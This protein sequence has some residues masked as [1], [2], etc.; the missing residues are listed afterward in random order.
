MVEESGAEKCTEKSLSLAADDVFE[1]YWWYA[2]NTNVC[3]R[4]FVN[5]ATLTFVHKKEARQAANRLLGNGC[6]YVPKFGNSEAFIKMTDEMPLLLAPRDKIVTLNIFGRKFSVDFTTSEDWSTERV[7]L[8][9]PDG[10]VSFTDGSLCKGK[11]GASIFSDILNVRESYAL[12]S[13]ATVFQSEVYAILACSEYC[14]S[15]GIVNRVV[16]ICSD[17]RTALLA[18]KSCAVSSRVV[19]QC[20][21]SIQ[22]LALSNRVQLVWV[23]G[24]FG[25]H[26]NSETDALA[27]AGLSSD[28]VRRAL[29]SV[30]TF[31]CQAEG[32]KVVTYISLRLMKLG[33]CL[34]SVENVAEKAQ[35]RIDEILTEA[36]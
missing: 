6:S 31:E 17:S 28:S 9:A 11:A 8:V 12:G 1:N 34:S 21:D 36:A 24:H 29:S 25:I 32:A 22:E 20:K 19:P 33:D 5:V 3:F 7:D 13:H 4:G 27:R 23:P 30:S 14:I 2:F 16:S 10:L 15:E 18:F 35:S 26:G